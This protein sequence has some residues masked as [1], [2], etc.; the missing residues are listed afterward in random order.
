MNP[1]NKGF[2]QI[3]NLFLIREDISIYEKMV[4]IILKKYAMRKNH[5]WP[6]HITI[7]KEAGCGVTKVKKAITVLEGK[8]L[9]TKGRDKS[10]RSN[11]YEIKYRTM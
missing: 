7:A 5:C 10:V 8:G 11:V 4:F 1:K 3:P 2:T 9:I 6:A